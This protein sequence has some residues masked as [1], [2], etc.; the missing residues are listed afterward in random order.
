MSNN[1]TY[2][3]YFSLRGNNTVPAQVKYLFVCI[4]LVIFVWC[5]FFKS[6]YSL[7]GLASYPILFFLIK[8]RLQIDFNTKMCRL[9]VDYFGFTVGQWIPLPQAEYVSVFK[10]QY[11]NTKFEDGGG[12]NWNDTF[13]RIEVNLVL[14]RKETITAW[15]GNNKAEAMKA[16]KFIAKN[17]ELRVLDATQREFVWLDEK[18]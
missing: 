8:Q 12:L 17:L 4:T 16:A 6:F 14:N 1:P 13:D 9:G 3:F 15:V 5:Y 10:K 7:I 2:S 11:S 18:K